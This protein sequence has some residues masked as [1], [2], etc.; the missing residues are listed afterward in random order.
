MAL[1]DIRV[2]DEVF[3]SEGQ[4]GIGAVRIVRPKTLLVQIE[5]FGEI[6]IGP[7][8]IASAHD[9]KVVLKL[10]ALDP[11]LREH[12]AHAHDLEY[13]DPARRQ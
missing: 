12:L 9:G 11:K 8:H 4:I 1:K 5:G 3:A 2:E 13:K 10:D 6:E 7:D